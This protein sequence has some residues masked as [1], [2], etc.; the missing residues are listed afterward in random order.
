MLI[1]IISGDV[2]TCMSSYRAELGGLIAILYTIYRICQYYQVAS[3]KFKYYCDDKG[4]IRNVF[5]NKPTTITQLLHADYDLVQIAKTLVTLIPA[6]IVVEWVNGQYTGDNRE[7]KHDLNDMAD[8]LATTFNRNPP[9]AYKQ[10]RMPCSI[11]GYAIRLQYDG[12]TITSN[13]YRTMSQAFHRP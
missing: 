11:P 10:R 9:I 13:L 6:T 1:L 7:Q 3:G 4:V 2:T 5:S 12:S 8:K